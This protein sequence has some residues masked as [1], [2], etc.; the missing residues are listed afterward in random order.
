VIPFMHADLSSAISHVYTPCGCTFTGFREEE[1]SREYGACT[2]SVDQ[3]S[4]RFRVAKITPTKAG[5]FVTLWKRNAAGITQPYDSSD[6]ID[7]Y[8]ISVR[9]EQAFGQFV[10]PKSVLI[11]QGIVSTPVKEGKRGFRVY[12]PWDDAP[13]RQA[14]KTREWQ[15]KFFLEIQKGKPVDAVRAKQV[16]ALR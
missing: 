7:L 4:V 5:Q 8:V 3:A 2:F 16:Y 6:P 1:E 13:N 9:K 12:P 10:F 14:Q 11:E 15:L